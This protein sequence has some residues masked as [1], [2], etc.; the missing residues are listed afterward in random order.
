MSEKLLTLG[1]SVQIAGVAELS[2]ALAALLAA[3]EPSIEVDCSAVRAIDGAS[4]QCL[5]AARRDARLSGGD[6]QL[7]RPSED[8][9]RYAG[10]LGLTAEL[11]SPA[12]PDSTAAA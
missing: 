9:L 7:V 1:E 2:A 10:Y 11:I 5:L 6:L 12:G 3:T 8:F 4:L